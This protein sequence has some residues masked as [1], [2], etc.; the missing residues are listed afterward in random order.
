MK[1]GFATVVVALGVIAVLTPAS[2]ETKIC[3][4]IVTVNWT[5]GVSDKDSANLDDSFLIR[6]DDI[7]ASCLFTRNSAAGKKVLAVCWFGYPC[8]ARV[9][10][11]DEDEADVSIVHDVL[12]VEP[13]ATPRHR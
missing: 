12:T 6:A 11:N 10:I 4:G 7:T 1:L 9:T 8:K 13:L 5:E 2:A 3:R